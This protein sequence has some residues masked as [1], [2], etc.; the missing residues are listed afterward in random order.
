MMATVHGKGA[1]I[2]G[3]SLVAL[4][5]AHSFGLPHPPASEL[6]EFM[7][8]REAFTPATSVREA[9][10]LALGCALG[11]AR[12]CVVST[13]T[14]LFDLMEVLSYATSC[15]IPL[16]VIQVGR[17]LP[18]FGNPYPYQGDFDLLTGGDYPPL[19]VAPS[20]PEEIPGLMARAVTLS[21]RFAVPLVFYL[22]SALFHM[23]GRVEVERQDPV[24]PR[25]LRMGDRKVFTSIHLDVA[26]MKEKMEFLDRT[27]E[28]MGR[29]GL[30]EPYRVD[31]ARL[32]LVAYGVC[33][34]VAKEVVDD[35]RLK[36]LEVGLIRPVT[37]SPLAPAKAFPA[38][39]SKIV[40]VEMSNGQLLRS[41]RGR[42]P[43]RTLTGFTTRAGFIPE[44]EEL[45]RFAEGAL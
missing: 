9:G 5:V 22:D 32:A 45:S 37:L 38:A 40:V 36:G 29:E 28:A 27:Y 42:L 19:V 8:A 23:T 12:A 13:G 14:D 20:F 21:E 35:L 41:L 33:A 1:E 24:V 43:R 11:G 44:R 6:C 34:Y 17:S 26:A 16:T 31:D 15:A 30:V 7:A 2:I 10:F 4:G 18:G 25:G 3:A 39:I